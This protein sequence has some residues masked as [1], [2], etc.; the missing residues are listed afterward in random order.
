MKNYFGR[1]LRDVERK[2][3]PEQFPEWEDLL[4][5]CYRVYNQRRSDSK[6]L[7]SFHAPEVECISKGKVHKKYEFG[8]KVRVV[9]TTRDNWVLGIQALHGNPYNGHTLA[10]IM[11]DGFIDTVFVDR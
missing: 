3:T 10:E 6:K 9:A 7:Y 1:V 2:L 5:R 11:T 8:W 4:T